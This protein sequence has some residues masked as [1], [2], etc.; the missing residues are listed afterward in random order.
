MSATLCLHKGSCQRLNIYLWVAVRD[1]T[2]AVFRDFVTTRGQLLVPIWGWRS[3]ALWLHECSS[4]RLSDYLSAA[5]RDFVTIW[6]QL[7]GTLCLPE[8]SCQGLCV[9]LRA[10]IRDS[11]TTWV[12]LPF[13]YLSAAFRTLCLPEGCCQGLCARLGH[14]GWYDF[15]P[16]STEI[17]DVFVDCAFVLCWEVSNNYQSRKPRTDS[18]RIAEWWDRKG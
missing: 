6:V 17:K 15:H 2:S 1:C 10:A 9:Y 5:L 16:F 12:Q 7:S 3:G 18:K 14:P 11:L 13:D 8:G 4:K